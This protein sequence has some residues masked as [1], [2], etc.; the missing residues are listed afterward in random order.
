MEAAETR[1]RNRLAMEIHDTLGHALTGIITGIEACTV[2]M[3]AAPEADKMQLKAIAEV[4]R[5][6]LRM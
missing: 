5:Q 2:L 4:A 3:D 1:E 6:G